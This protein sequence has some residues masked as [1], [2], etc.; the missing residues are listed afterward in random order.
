MD[1]NELTFEPRH[2]G[3]PPGAPKQFL[4]LWYIWRKP[5]TY[6]ALKLRLS[7]NGPKQFLI[8]WYVW[9]KPC[10]YHAPKPTLSPKGPK[11]DST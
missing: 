1:Q 2:L 5:C 3:V 11:G 9:R 7:P 6:L 4:R 10:T 8:L